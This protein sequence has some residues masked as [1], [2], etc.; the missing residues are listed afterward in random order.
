MQQ[1]GKITIHDFVSFVA[2]ERKIA[3]QL[4][5]RWQTESIKGKTRKMRLLP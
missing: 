5:Q 4:I 1:V 2:V 3:Q